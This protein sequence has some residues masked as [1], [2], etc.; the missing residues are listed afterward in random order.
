MD[1]VE[2]IEPI[3]ALL[4]FSYSFPALLPIVFILGSI[5]YF[6]PPN[7]SLKFRIN[8]GISM[9]LL[10]FPSLVDSSFP[11]LWTFVTLSFSF[12][13]FL[14]LYKIN[15]FLLLFLSGCISYYLKDRMSTL[16]FFTVYKS[17]IFALPN[18][19]SMAE[20]SLLVQSIFMIF[21][22][23]KYHSEEELNVEI[24]IRAVIFGMLLIG[25]LGYPILKFVSFSYIEG[26]ANYKKMSLVFYFY[27]ICFVLL[28]RKVVM[29]NGIYH[30]DPFYWTI[31]FLL[32]NFNMLALWVSCLLLT[33]TLAHIWSKNNLL[34]KSDILVES[35][36]SKLYL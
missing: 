18:I 33:I 36:I 29:D 9:S 5:L 4:T 12:L 22:F 23:K 8:S 21:V 30:G 10:L 32:N 34:Q 15:T 14:D 16:I 28:I 17:L 2:F 13:I 27:F 11:Q 3:L 24:L 6:Y 20:A 25:I 26:H 31:L 19:F 35:K 1:Y 7:L